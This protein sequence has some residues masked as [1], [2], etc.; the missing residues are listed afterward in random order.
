VNPLLINIADGFDG[1]SRAAYRLHQG[2]RKSNVN[3]NMLV[4]Y[5]YVDEKHVLGPQR[6]SSRLLA[7]VKPYID[8]VPVHLYPQRQ[9][10]TFYPQWAPDYI[11][12]KVKQMQPDILNLHWVCGGLLKIETLAKLN[13]PLV[14]TLHDMWPFTGG[15]H[16]SQECQRYTISC[17]SCPQL[18]SN[19][20]K[21]L[22]RWVWQRKL[23]AWKNISFLIV[24]PSHWLAECSRKSALFRNQRVEVIPNGLDLQR[25][26]PF[27]KSLVRE[28]LNLPQ[29]KL[30]VMFASN[31]ATSDRRKGFHLLQPALKSLGHSGWSDK[32][33]LLVMGAGEP[34][35]P[36]DLGLKAHYLGTLKEDI[37]MA[38]YYAA[39]DVFV[40]PSLE[41]N[42]P[43]TV[44]E[45][46][47]CGTPCVAF[48]IGGMPDL[49]DHQQNGYL[50]QAFE[51]EDLAQGIAWVLQ[52]SDRLQKLS[53]AARAKA[54]KEFSLELQ[55][56]RYISL[57]EEVLAAWKT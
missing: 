56:R 26:K 2:L 18:R 17:G 53:H 14:W 52:D 51:I 32:V 9:D 3:S 44:L 57:Y 37:T 34:S 5:K 1:A 28:W 35:P 40:A 10:L 6:L 48:N 38:L 12:R 30:I 41:D 45:A 8:I 29:D 43:N 39:A 4:Q 36:M 23:N 7:K 31:M 33:E 13:L 15:C 49:I 21:D 27:N 25:Y 54:E 22:S 55:A 50:A 20:E 19:K 42:L 47:A 24:T 11:Q 46:L 16:Y